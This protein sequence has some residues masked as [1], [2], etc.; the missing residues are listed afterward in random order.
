MCDPRKPCGP[1]S[2]LISSRSRSVE[3]RLQNRDTTRRRR[4]DAQRNVPSVPRPTRVSDGAR[5]AAPTSEAT[6]LPPRGRFGGREL[7]FKR[8]LH[9]V[10]G[11]IELLRTGGRDGGLLIGPFLVARQ[12]AVARLAEVVVEPA[13]LY[14]IIYW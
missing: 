10:P 14:H 6:G 13:G 12:R 9:A 5:K 1:C 11:A 4:S 3:M 7:V 8:T 2:H